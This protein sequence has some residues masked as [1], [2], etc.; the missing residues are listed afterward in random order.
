V[1]GFGGGE[2]ASV[3]NGRERGGLIRLPAIQKGGDSLLRTRKGKRGKVPP[4][5]RREDRRKKK[6]IST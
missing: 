3:T 1:A 2:G 5:H 6:E 4:N